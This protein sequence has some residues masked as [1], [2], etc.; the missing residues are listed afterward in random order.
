[1]RISDW[2]SDVCSSDLGRPPRARCPEGAGMTA[3]EDVLGFWFAPGREAQWFEVSETFDG[4]VRRALLSHFEAARLGKYESWRREPRGCV[5]LCLLFD[6]M[7]RNVFRGDRKS[8]RMNYS[9]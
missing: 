5:A 8:T 4:E 6:Q 3:L 7:P 2:S 9:H 1:M